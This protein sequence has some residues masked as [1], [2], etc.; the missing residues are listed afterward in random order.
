MHCSR[1]LAGTAPSCRLHGVQL[2]AS[3]GRREARGQE[4]F[5]QRCEAGDAGDVRC[6]QASL[7]AVGDKSAAKG[8]DSA[9]A[10]SRP[11]SS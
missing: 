3:W 4:L 11:A 7:Q 10:A 1:R 2:Q 6:A 8:R 5:Y 9:P